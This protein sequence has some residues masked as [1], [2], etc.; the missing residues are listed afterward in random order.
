[1]VILPDGYT[2]DEFAKFRNDIDS[3]ILKS[4]FNRTPF[5]EYA[6]YFNVFALKVPSNQ[7]GASHPGHSSDNDCGDQPVQVVDNYFGSS[8]DCGGGSYHRLLCADHYKVQQTLVN[9]FNAYDLCL[10]LVNTPYY[11]GSGGEIAVSSLDSYAPEV[12][13]HEEGH[14]F[15]GLSD[16]YWAGSQYAH[17]NI[18]MT[19]VSDT[20]TVKWKNWLNYKG[21]GIYPHS[22]DT[23]WF[24]PHQECQMR[25]LNREF[26]SVCTEAIIEKIHALT[27]SIYDYSPNNNDNVNINSETIK[28]TLTLIKPEPNTL[29]FKWILDDKP[30]ENN[31]DTLLVKSELLS[32]GD[33]HLSVFIL[34]TSEMVRTRTHK[35]DHIYEVRW[36]LRKTAT[37]V[38]INSE[39]KHRAISIYP[40]PVDNILKIDLDGASK[41]SLIIDIYDTEGKR[42]ANLLSDASENAIS[43]YEFNLAELN[44]PAGAYIIKANI[45]GY[46]I[47]RNIVKI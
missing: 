28:F 27:S 42:V 13:I 5:K 44:L 33:H 38:D 25:L 24:R 47:T 11:G 12:A 8:F 6:N 3:V 45:D 14:S 10:L 36:T 16:E 29:S 15:G 35:R 2:K 30:L 23:T 40:N 19:A 22:E 41:S 32:V 37:S 4:F 20:N 9:N 17:E 31:G 39:T 43:N 46:I 34:D 18:N 7:S 21:V 26:C 1:M